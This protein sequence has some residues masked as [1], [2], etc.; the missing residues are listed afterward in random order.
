MIDGHPSFMWQNFYQTKNIYEDC[1]V[2][3]YNLIIFIYIHTPTYFIINKE[4]I[5]YVNT[6]KEI[7]DE[8]LY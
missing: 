5:I 2:I 7:V 8:S 3:D 4:N 6:P 1:N